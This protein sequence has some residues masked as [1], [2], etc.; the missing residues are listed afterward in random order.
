MR[1]IASVLP[2]SLLLMSLALPLSA[3][4]KPSAYVPIEQRLTAEQMQATGLS[5]LTGQQL[6]LLNQLLDED[7]A[8]AIQAAEVQRAQD[9]AGKREKHTPAQTVVATVPGQA[10]S[11]T[12]GRML[13]L[14]NGQ[15]WRIVDGGVTF[16]RPRTDPKVTIAPGFLGAWYLRLD[17]GTPPIKVQRVD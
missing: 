14:D 4:Q 15:R 5:T 9:D 8:Q 7:R 16:P 17:D 1:R 3:G 11:W 2:M 13:T 10:S 12:Q 6:G